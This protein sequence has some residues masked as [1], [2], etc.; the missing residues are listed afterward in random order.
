MNN[1]IQASKTECV[2]TGTGLLAAVALLAGCASSQPSTAAAGRPP[3]E[4]TATAGTAPVRYIEYTGSRIPVR[5]TGKLKSSDLA[6]NMNVVDP[7]SPINQGHPVLLDTLT[8]APWA[9]PGYRG[10]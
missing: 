8:S 7:D 10:Y 1:P 4:R 6:V 9:Y 3:R 2:L 5:V